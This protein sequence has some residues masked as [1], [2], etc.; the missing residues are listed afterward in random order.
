MSKIK[1]AEKVDNLRILFEKLNNQF[2]KFFF[3]KKNINFLKAKNF[4][5]KKYTNK[6]PRILVF[7]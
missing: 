7:S 4:E 2:E 6:I 5:N 3:Y 1:L